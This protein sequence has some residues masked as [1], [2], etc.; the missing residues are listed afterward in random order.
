MHPSNRKEALAHGKQHREH[1][2]RTAQCEWAP[3]NHRDPLAL[4]RAI[5]RT[6]IHAL[7]PIKVER[8][9]V[10]PFA[11]F[12]G[13]AP[14]MAADMAQ[15]PSSGLTV[16]I[17]GD[18]HV[19]NLG[20]FAAP[21]GTIIFDIND[22][23][24][25]IIAPWEWDIRRLAVSI[26]LAGR[27]AGQSERACHDAALRFVSVYRRSL[28]QLSKL[29]VLQLHRYKVHRHLK[30]MS[31]ESVFRKAQRATP[32]ETL[33]KFARKDAKGR[34]RFIE[35][36][37]AFF[38]VSRQ[39]ERQAL[40][41]LGP[42]RDTLSPER[43]HVLDAYTPVDVI[44]KVVGTGSVGVRDYVILMLGRDESDPLFIQIK[45]EPP[46]CYSP[47]L[48]DSA[49]VGHQGRRVVMGQ[50]MLQAQ[51]DFLLGW[52]SIAGREYLVRQLNDHKATIQ[53]KDLK[54]NALGE[55]AALCGEVFAKAHGR[56]S[57]PCLIAGYLG[58][59]G[60]FDDALAK[61]AVKYADQMEKDYTKFL[62]A[63]RRARP[64]TAAKTAAKKMAAK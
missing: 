11:Y 13:S 33:R 26:V 34:V 60:K 21:D 35:N 32:Q 9:S 1:A 49:G 42:Y 23:D 41:A 16:Q 58:E 20:S 63:H 7:Y 36:R 47:Y 31:M 38:R 3:A 39:D 64:K 6:R 48:P 8:M 45:E 12:R 62:V 46:S 5:E 61:F 51:S 50:R 53:L 24:E 57:N 18:A 44:F 22:F 56:S 17:C 10:S 15:M 59:S 25:T 55:Y 30:T 27:E 14:V 54:G 19:N 43:Q 2:G 29:T 37:P 40:A 52:T 28:H 4:L